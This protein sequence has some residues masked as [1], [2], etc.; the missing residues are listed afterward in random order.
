MEKHKDNI[1]LSS[2]A[3][4]IALGLTL[5]VGMFLLAICNIHGE[6]GNQLLDLLSAVYP[7]FTNTF[8]GA[9]VGLLW[10]SFNGFIHGFI[11]ALIYNFIIRH[12]SC[13]SCCKS[14]CR[15]KSE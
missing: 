15:S 14:S 11:I 6:V 2:C 9:V 5:G 8:K 3:L 4:G 10:G 1:R 12:C 13:R 7:G